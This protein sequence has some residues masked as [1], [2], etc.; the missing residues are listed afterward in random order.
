MV[1]AKETTIE[2]KPRVLVIIDPQRDFI[3]GALPNEEAQKAVPNIAEKIKAFQGDAILITMDTHDE[4]YLN[5]TEGKKLPIK[6]CIYGT[7]GWKLNPEIQHA[8]EDKELLGMQIEYIMKPTFGS[9]EGVTVEIEG[10]HTYNRSLVEHILDI[11]KRFCTK[12]NIHPIPMEIE[13]C[14][15]CTDICVVSNA[16]ILK[17]F[18]YD[19]AEITVDAQCCAGVTP[20]KHKAALEVMK[21]CQIN[22]TNELKD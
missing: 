6:H 10:E 2:Y 16:L 22:V 1:E 4:N 11:E 5:T 9:V 3:Y 21:S 12:N 17:A 14:G 13:M 18:T 20:E 8:L 19:F 15:F 7:E